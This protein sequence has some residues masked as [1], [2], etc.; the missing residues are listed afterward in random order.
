MKLKH[1]N[2]NKLIKIIESI[3]N[4]L[5]N[6]HHHPINENNSTDIY[7]KDHKL[8]D[9]LFSHNLKVTKPPPSI[10]GSQGVVYFMGDKI[11]KISKDPIEAKLANILKG[12]DIVSIIDILRIDYNTWGI[13]QKAVKFDKKHPIVLGLDYLM[14]YIDDKGHEGIN[15]PKHEI[16]DYIHHKWG[17]ET[18]QA[19]LNTAIDMILH[20]KDKTGHTIDDAVP[21]NVGIHNGKVVFTDLGP[22]IIN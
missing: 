14:A 17:D 18:R 13:L 12:D 22:N 7:F 8:L 21:S 5:I 9:W 16:I 1:L 20:I 10:K 15:K 11:L 3:K 19:D 2:E 6:H 4:F